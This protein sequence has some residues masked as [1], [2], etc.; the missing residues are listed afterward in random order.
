MKIKQYRYYISDY[1]GPYGLDPY[2]QGEQRK[3]QF[4][5]KQIK[6]LTIQNNMRRFINTHKDN[7]VDIRV[8][9]SVINTHNN[10][11]LNTILETV[12]ILYNK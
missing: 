10:G 6:A 4:G 11:G 8:I 7:I 2:Y 9:Q 1:I 3:H 5:Y 12:T